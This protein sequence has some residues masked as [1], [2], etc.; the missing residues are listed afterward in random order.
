MSASGR[1]AAGPGRNQDESSSSSRTGRRSC[2]RVRGRSHEA[3]ARRSGESTLAA[4]GLHCGSESPAL[5]A[6][7]RNPPGHLWPLHSHHGQQATRSLTVPEVNCVYVDWTFVSFL[8]M[9][10]SSPE[11]VCPFVELIRV[12]VAQMAIRDHSEMIHDLYMIRDRL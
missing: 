9:I 10:R 12:A 4:P 3:P 2:L 1:L 5:W 11:Q 8:D 6:L 7:H